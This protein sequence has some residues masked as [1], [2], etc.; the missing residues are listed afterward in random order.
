MPD[1]LLPIE[2]C[3]RLLGPHVS[4]TDEEL[5]AVRQKVLDLA[6]VVT[7]VYSA[8]KAEVDH[9]DPCEIGA[10]GHAGMLKLSGL[11]NDG[12]DIDEILNGE[13]SEEDADE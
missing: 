1:E 7:A 4:M 3:R 2:M 11:Q 8:F 6:E 10:S 12:D 13:Q 9:F 5:R